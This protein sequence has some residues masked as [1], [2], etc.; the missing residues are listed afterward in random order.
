M[1]NDLI[2]NKTKAKHK[3]NNVLQIFSFCVLG[4]DLH[5]NNQFNDDFLFTLRSHMFKKQVSLK[6]S[7]KTGHKR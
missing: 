4:K 6:P 1:C 5:A 2:L 3:Q 7:M